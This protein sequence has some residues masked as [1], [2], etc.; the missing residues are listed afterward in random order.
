MTQDKIS[1]IT[2]DEFKRTPT[3]GLLELDPL[4]PYIVMLPTDTPTEFAQKISA[5]MSAAGIFAIILTG[6]SSMKVFSS[7]PVD[8]KLTRRQMEVCEEALDKS[9]SEGDSI[10]ITPHPVKKPRKR[11][12]KKSK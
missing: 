3:C 5:D 2:P 4:K 6:P 10:K 12:T 9:N 8:I 1:K 7:F 11:A